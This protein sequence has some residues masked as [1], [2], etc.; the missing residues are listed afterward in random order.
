MKKFC[1]SL[2]E[3]TMKI[4]KFK[5]KRNEF[6]KQKPHENAKICCIFKENIVKLETIAIIQG[7]IEVLGVVESGG[8]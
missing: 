3:N 5:K 1:E 2:K 4:I 8:I 6:I 7:D